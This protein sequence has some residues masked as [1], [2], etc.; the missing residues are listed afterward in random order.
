MSTND[1]LSLLIVGISSVGFLVGL[2][3]AIQWLTVAGIVFIFIGAGAYRG[4]K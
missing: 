1:K 4:G 3:F 2:I